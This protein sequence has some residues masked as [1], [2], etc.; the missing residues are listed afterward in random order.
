[1]PIVAHGITDTLDFL[2]IFLHRYP[3][4]HF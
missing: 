1:V 4:M 2:L 3:G